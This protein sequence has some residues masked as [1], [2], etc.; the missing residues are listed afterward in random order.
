MQCNIKTFHRKLCT[1]PNILFVRAQPQA[2]D[3]RNMV[4]LKTGGSAFVVHPT[5]H[6]GQSSQT[7]NSRAH[8][9]EKG[10]GM[11]LSGPGSSTTLWVSSS[12]FIQE[13][14]KAQRNAQLSTR[15]A[16]R[17]SRSVGH[18]VNTPRCQRQAYL[19]KLPL[20]TRRQ[21]QGDLRCLFCRPREP[22]LQH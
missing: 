11:A 6:C 7:S 9:R 16:D 10:M 20:V 17:D 8:P 3:S 15:L 2:G 19:R 18:S 14:T 13:E 1:D 5:P 4:F 21:T 12:H 22:H